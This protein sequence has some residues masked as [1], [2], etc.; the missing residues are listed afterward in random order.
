MGNGSGDRPDAERV[1]EASALLLLEL[2]AKHSEVA[3]DPGD[4]TVKKNLGFLR[5][6][7][8][9]I[10]NIEFVDADSDRPYLAIKAGKFEIVDRQVF[11]RKLADAT[12]HEIISELAADLLTP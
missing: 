1:F 3:A 8:K 2:P 10:E 4:L 12:L 5:Q 9:R 7:I 6:C 11:E